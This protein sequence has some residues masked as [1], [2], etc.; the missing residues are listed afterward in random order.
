MLLMFN[1]LTALLCL[2]CE[3]PSDVCRRSDFQASSASFCFAALK[4]RACGLVLWD[5]GS[6]ATGFGMIRVSGFCSCFALADWG[7]TKVHERIRKPLRSPLAF[8]KST[9][10]GTFSCKEEKTSFM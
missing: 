10:M 8:I 6:H 4:V 9:R 5:D 7:S 2:K 3:R 1:T